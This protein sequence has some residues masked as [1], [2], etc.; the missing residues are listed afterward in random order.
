[1][2]ENISAVTNKI[3]LVITDSAWVQLCRVGLMDGMG[4]YSLQ[5][6]QSTLHLLPSCADNTRCFLF[7]NLR[8]YTQERPTAYLEIISHSNY[9]RPSSQN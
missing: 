4:I 7:H 9:I 5:R 2:L 3:A 1:M 8:D 6:T